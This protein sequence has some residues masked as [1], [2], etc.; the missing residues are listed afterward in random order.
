MQFNLKKDGSNKRIV[1][2]ADQNFKIYDTGIPHRLLNCV[3]GS[4][5]TLLS[6]VHASFKTAYSVFKIINI[7]LPFHD[8][9]CDV[10]NCTGFA[11]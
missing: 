8:C 3:R 6:S 2:K 10:L 11:L 9:C 5:A 1:S 7:N 4:F